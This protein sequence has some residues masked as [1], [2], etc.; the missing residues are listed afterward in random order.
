M[1]PRPITDPRTARLV[2]AYEALRPDTVPDLLALYD[3][4]ALFKDPFNE[5][6][7]QAAIGRIF[8]HMFQALAAPRFEVR[9]AV[10]EGNDAFL[11]WDFH[12][13]RRGQPERWTIRGA[14]H[15]LYT[16]DGRVSVHRDYWDAAEELYAKLPLL[17]VLMRAL[18]RR[19]GTPA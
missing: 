11:T 8:A 5:V 15:L 3:D 13:A 16:P 4:E 18:Q 6:R 14:S 10:T 19:L 17:G 9:V 7:G 12:F 2:A 1:P